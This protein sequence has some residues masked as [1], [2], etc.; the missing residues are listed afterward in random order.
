MWRR[1]A[2]LV[3]A[4]PAAPCRAP[5]ATLPRIRPNDRP[6]PRSAPASWPAQSSAAVIGPARV[7]ASGPVHILRRSRVRRRLRPCSTYAFV[8]CVSARHCRAETHR[9]ARTEMHADRPGPRR[10]SA[11]FPARPGL[12]GTAFRAPAAPGLDPPRARLRDVRFCRSDDAAFGRFS[13]EVG[14]PEKTFDAARTPWTV[15]AVAAGM[16]TSAAVFAQTPSKPR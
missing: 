2:A 5:A 3:P 11:L 15:P 9:E 12:A 1:L 16:P 4:K 10:P 6:P 13:P 8:R 7:L 14:R